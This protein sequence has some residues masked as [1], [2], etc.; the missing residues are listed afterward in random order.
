MSVVYAMV[1]I[2]VAYI[3]GSIPMGYLIAQLRGVNVLE[4]GSGRTGSTNVL[5]SAG[6]IAAL[7]TALGDVLKGLIPTAMAVFIFQDSLPWVPPLVGAT[8]IL[9]HNYSIFLQFKGGAGGITCFAALVALAFYP[10]VIASFLAI[11]VMFITRFASAGTFS[12]AVAGLI[13]L[14]IYIAMGQRP[15]EYIIFG[16][17]SVLLIGWAL[18]TNFS[19]I[20]AGTERRIGSS[21]DQ[22][23]Q[24]VN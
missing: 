3:C 9:G 23:K 7:F 15:G 1:A 6:L 17:L 19:R 5:R 11:I 10:G 20:I 22:V 4:V 8:T 21:D 13:G 2:V 24:Q 12:G 16:F 18:R 14:S